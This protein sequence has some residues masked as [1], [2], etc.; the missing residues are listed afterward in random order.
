MICKEIPVDTVECDK[1]EG[2]FCKLC[3]ERYQY[4]NKIKK[5]AK[6][7]K[8]M[9]ECPEYHKICEKRVVNKKLD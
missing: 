1:C 7:T 9:M 6:I 4:L 2:L 5:G 3:L 8:E